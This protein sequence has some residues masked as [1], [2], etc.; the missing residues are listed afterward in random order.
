MKIVSFNVNGIRARM[1]QLEAIKQNLIADV[2]GL[3][4]VK[5]MPDQLPVAE[6]EALGWHTEVHSQKAHYGVA[7]LSVEKPLTVQKGFPSDDDDSQK[8]FIHTSH[9]TPNGEI[10]HI[11]N[12]YFPQGENRSHETKFPAKQKYY[13]DLLMYL[14]ANFTANDNIIVMGDINVAPID[15]DIGIGEANAKRWLKTGKC[16]FLPEER[17]WVQTLLDWGLTDSYRLLNPAIT[18]RF[19]WFDYRSKGFEDTPKRGLRIDLIM[20]SKPLIE[21]L[22]NAGIDYDT[23]SMEKP[24]D[25]APIFIELDY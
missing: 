23:R 17:E 4:E 10:L 1:H 2:L 8:R 19:S 14:D 3:Q 16:A 5:A 9:Q 20:I 18:D 11:I 24:S 15:Q 12:G 25:H 22:V 7:T 6:I 21:R 13:A